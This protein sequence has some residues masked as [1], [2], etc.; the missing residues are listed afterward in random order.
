M[1]EISDHI[2]LPNL[3]SSKNPTFN[4]SKQSQQAQQFSPLL[5][6]LTLTSHCGH[7]SSWC[8]GERHFRHL[9]ARLTDPWHSDPGGSLPH[10]P[11]PDAQEKH[12]GMPAWSLD[13]DLPFPLPPLPW[14]LVWF[15]EWEVWWDLRFLSSSLSAIALFFRACLLSRFDCLFLSS[16]GSSISE[17][18]I[19]KPGTFEVTAASVATTGLPL[20]P[21]A[22]QAEAG[23]CTFSLQ[24][25]SSLVTCM[26]MQLHGRKGS[27][28]LGTWRPKLASME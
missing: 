10:T 8:E 22:T 6:R 14:A 18:A 26:K 28:S 19:D 11:V 2:N 9:W 1:H 17:V 21:D 4:H 12:K 27:Q 7:A 23:T 20:D 25:A 24:Y 16:L 15:E 13:F 5:L 3:K